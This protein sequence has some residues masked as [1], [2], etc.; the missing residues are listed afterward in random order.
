MLFREVRG[1]RVPHPLG[2]ESIDFAN[3]VNGQARWLALCT[4]HVSAAVMGG[5]A[6]ITRCTR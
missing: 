6:R 5:A 1:V 3:S 2:D 4:F